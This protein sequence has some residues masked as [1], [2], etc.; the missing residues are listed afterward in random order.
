MTSQTTK[1]SKTI[2]K[3][4]ATKTITGI[5]LHLS[6]F[7][8]IPLEAETFT[9]VTL[10]GVFQ[11]E[12][13]AINDADAA[14]AVWHQK[15]LVAKGKVARARQVRGALKRWI[16]ATQG[17]GAVQVYED[18]GM[19]PPKKPGVKTAASKAASVAKAR[20]TRAAKKAALAAAAAPKTEPTP[21]AK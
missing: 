18:L 12:L 11:E 10:T 17:P 14:M 2:E 13:S 9:P 3:D 4:T 21:P 6:T 15:V 7:T 5:G 1:T 20:A 8:T 19:D 16:V